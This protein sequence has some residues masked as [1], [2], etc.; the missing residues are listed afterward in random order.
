MILFGKSHERIFIL[1]K[2]RSRYSFD[3]GLFFLIQLN[4]D[5]CFENNE[6]LTYDTLGNI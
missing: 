3:D 1:L 6:N 4:D 2:K 5:K